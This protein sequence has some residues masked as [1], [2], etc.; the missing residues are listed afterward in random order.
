[1]QGEV[2]KKLDIAANEILL[3]TCAWGGQVAG[4][5]SEE[6]PDGLRD[7]AAA[8]QGS[9]LLLFDPLDGS[10]QHRRQRLG[11]HHLLDP[12]RARRRRR[13]PAE[14]DFLQPGTEQVAAGYAIYGPTTML[15]LTV[16]DGVARLHARPRASATSC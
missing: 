8:P 2:Q 4:M 13:T 9:Y 7:P 1:M 14:A 6:L 15:V 12:A 16:G 5:A 11:R 10:S 3:D